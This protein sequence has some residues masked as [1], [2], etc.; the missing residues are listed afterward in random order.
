MF[1]SLEEAIRLGDS[2]HQNDGGVPIFFTKAVAYKDA[3]GNVDYRDELWVKIHNKGDRLNIMERAK[4]PEDEKRWPA[5]WAA[6]QNNTEAA[7]DGIPL[8]DFPA[9]TPAERMKCKAL[10]LRSVEDLANYPDG[11]IKDLGQRGHLLQKKAREFIE[12]RKGTEVKDLK[13]RIA[14]LEKLINESNSS[15]DNRRSS[16]GDEPTSDGDVR[17][18]RSKPVRK[19][20]SK[21]ANKRKST[22]AKTVAGDGKRG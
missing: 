17:G 21:S 6:Y 11:Q 9:I 3:D 2:K 13:A 16:S 1:D 10:H 14:E 12:F 5:Q 7:I 15:S 20:S 8:D 22:K 4:R 19:S 18:G